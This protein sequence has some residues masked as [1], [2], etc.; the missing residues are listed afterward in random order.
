MPN[1]F[2]PGILITKDTLTP[3]MRKLPVNIK[4]RIGLYL[5][6]QETRVQDYARKNAPWTDRTSN[7][8]NGLHAQYV[9]DRDGDRHVIR[10]YHTVPYG[11]WLEIRWAGKYA[12]IVPT[13]QAEGTRIMAG[14]SKLLEKSG[15]NVAVSAGVGSVG[16]GLFA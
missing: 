15:F 9:G 8:R 6:G 4:G 14:M 16:S 10:L 11:I 13:I 12:I 1:S 3:N 5:K 2:M 7:A